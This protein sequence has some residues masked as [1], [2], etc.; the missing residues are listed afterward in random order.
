M[1]RSTAAAVALA[2]L[3]LAGCSSGGGDS[4]PWGDYAPDV[5]SRIDKL[6]SSKD[7]AGLQDSFDTA[8]ANNEATMKRTGHNNAALMTY[9]D[10]AMKSAGCY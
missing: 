4:V 7:C 3:V 9:I 6:A 2:G 1:N 8:D 10:D 5:Q